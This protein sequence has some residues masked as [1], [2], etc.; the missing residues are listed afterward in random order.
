MVIA[1]LAEGRSVLRNVSWCDDS[2]SVKAV[3]QQLGAT[4]TESGGNLIIE[5][6][7]LNIQ[8][9][10]F[11]VGESGLAVRM[12]S[13][14]L[15]LSGKD[16]IINGKGSLLNRPVN[17]IADALRQTGAEVTTNEGSL[18]VNIRGRIMPGKFEIDCFLT[19]QVLTGLLIALPLADD[20]SEIRFRNLISKTYIDMSIIIMRDFGV[21]IKND[22]YRT[23]FVKGNQR[24][25]ATEYEIEGD[26]SGAA[27]LLVAAA[28]A[29]EA[30]VL[31][32]DYRSKQADKKIIDVLKSAGAEVS[33]KEKSV[34]VKKKNLD[35]FKFDAT[36]CPDLFPPLV[37]LA[38]ACDGISIIKGVSRLKHK[39]SDRAETLQKEFEKAGVRIEIVDDNMKV[40]GS[41]IYGTTID[42]RGDHRIAMAA[43]V[44]N[45]VSEGEI[46]INGKNAV[47]KSY[48]HFFQDLRNLF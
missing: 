12:L 48:P 39:E 35:A 45:L 24:Y 33:V 4:V 13:P 38:V 29:G 40:Y 23:F 5:S 18:P 17:V 37:C 20:D 11:N 31:N 42:S 19:S 27:F 2:L 22:D 41:G 3:I 1:A 46:V 30:E 9:P 8:K 47:G 28:I 26:W 34:F 43:G 32:L 14:V 16:L 44:M 6:R 7:G 10:E 25:L 21:G 36:D 15:A